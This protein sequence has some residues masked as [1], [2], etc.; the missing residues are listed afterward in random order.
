MIRNK[1]YTNRLKRNPFGHGPFVAIELPKDNDADPM[2]TILFMTGEDDD[3]S[4]RADINQLIDKGK[5]L[6]RRTGAREFLA[7][8][9]HTSFILDQEGN[10]L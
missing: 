7:G 9:E 1:N 5:E 10:I 4:M 2:R 8:N 6:C 3:S